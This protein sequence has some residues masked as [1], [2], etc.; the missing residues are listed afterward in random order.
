MN[1][2]KNLQLDFSL[3]GQKHIIETL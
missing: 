1:K 3:L 2:H